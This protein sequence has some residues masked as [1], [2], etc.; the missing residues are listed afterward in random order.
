MRRSADSINCTQSSACAIWTVRNSTPVHTR[1]VTSSRTASVSPSC[2]ADLD[3]QSVHAKVIIFHSKY[4]HTDF[5][6]VE[7][8]FF[9][10]SLE[11]FNSSLRT[12]RTFSVKKTQLNVLVEIKETSAFNDKRCFFIYALKRYE[13]FIDMNRAYFFLSF[14]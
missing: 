8:N 5:S 3:A 9:L 10:P 4:K 1:F 2:H 7:L 6:R 12:M 14:F 13:F 11:R